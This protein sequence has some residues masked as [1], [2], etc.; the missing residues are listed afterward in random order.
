MVENIQR[1]AIAVAVVLAALGAMR[2]WREE[3]PSVEGAYYT[4]TQTGGEVEAAYTGMGSYAVAYAEYPAG[5]PLVERF[6]VWYPEAL[7]SEQGRA[8]PIVVMA[9][10]T[11]V[12]ASR[13]TALL[14]RLASWGFVVVG[15]EQQNAWSG[16]AS[17]DSLDLLVALNEDEDSVFYQKLDTERVGSAG[18]SQG[19]IGAINA[20]T[21]QENGWRYK[22]VYAASTPSSRYAAALNWEYDPSLLRTP[23][24]L[25]AGTGLLDAGD[26]GAPETMEPEVAEEAQ[27]ISIAPLWSQEEIYAQVPAATPKLRARRAGADH[28]EML[29][30]GDGYMTAWFMYWL[31][32]DE[33]AGRA[34]FG[35][36]AELLQNPLWQDVEKNL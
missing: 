25:A 8:W 21:R 3:V 10:G 26:T 35:D 28:A 20:V 15:N 29:Y 32:G 7:E 23:L 6:E 13:Y 1:I 24:F 17:A 14:R 31:Q 30:W 18:H 33:A 2:D 9:N 34:F 27:E 5:D 22:A 12:P 19:A 16:A 11:G 36:D 4:E